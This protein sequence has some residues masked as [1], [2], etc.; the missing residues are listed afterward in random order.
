MK[1]R[2]DPRTKLF[3]LF[4][5]S[6]IVMMSATTPLLWVL[7]IIM[8]MVPIGLMIMEKQYAAALRFFVLYTVAMIIMLTCI[9]E[10]SQGVVMA[11]LLGY[12]CIIVQFMPAAITAWYVVRTTKIGEMVSVMQK[13]HMPDG[14]TISG[15]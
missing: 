1:F 3:M 8:T 13:M 9:S 14:I 2:L 6:C 11:F 15:I 5:V 7:R 10:K 4:V 12:C